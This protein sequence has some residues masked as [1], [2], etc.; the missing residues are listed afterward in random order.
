MS[1]H[2]ALGIKASVVRSFPLSV[3]SKLRTMK[4]KSPI[5]KTSYKIF[6]LSLVSI[7]LTTEGQLI[8]QKQSVVRSFQTTDHEN[9]ISDFKNL[10]KNQFLPLSVVSKLRTTGFGNN[11]TTVH[12]LYSKIKS[13]KSGACCF[14][15][16][17]S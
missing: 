6:P 12:Y 5:L 10:I 8:L 17:N 13:C 3:V 9:K 4:I 16:F 15:L 1:Y 7:Q 2:I 14:F 11:W